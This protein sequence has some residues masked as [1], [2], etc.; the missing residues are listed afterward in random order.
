[1]I[2]Y[3]DIMMSVSSVLLIKSGT[4]ENLEK[5]KELWEYLQKTSPKLYRKIKLGILGRTMNLPGKAGRRIT[6]VAYKVA[7]KVVGFN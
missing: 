6:V 7:Q 1:M 4:E 2:N 3:V 5:K